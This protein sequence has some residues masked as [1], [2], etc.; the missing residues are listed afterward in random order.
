MV[1]IKKKA[2]K[3]FFSLQ[4]LTYAIVG[5]V[6]TVNG[7]ILALIYSN[8]FDENLSFIFGYITGLLFSYILNSIVTFK[9]SLSF[10]K[11][12]KYVI[13]YIPNFL[14][15]NIAVVVFYNILGW[16]KLIAYSL[17]AVVAVPITFLLMKYFTFGN[18]DLAQE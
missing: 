9:Q 17:A 2:L 18:K 5:T 15:Q 16:Y 7:I 1:E 10:K 3:D 4:F 14:I 12:I 13:S 11:F 8:F 6:N